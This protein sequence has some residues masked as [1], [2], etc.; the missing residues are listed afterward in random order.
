M[1]SSAWPDIESHPIETG[2]RAHVWTWADSYEVWV[3]ADRDCAWIEADPQR[4]GAVAIW[5]AATTSEPLI[6][7]DEGYATVL[8]L[9]GLTESS[10]SALLAS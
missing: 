6:L 2:P 8:P 10:L 1:A 3:P 7:C 4:V 9:N 5:L